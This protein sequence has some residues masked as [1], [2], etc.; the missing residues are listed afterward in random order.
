MA[1]HQTDDKPSSEPMLVCC[2]DEYMHHLA[3]MS[4]KKS[5][6]TAMI[7]GLPCNEYNH[8]FVPDYCISISNVLEFPACF[9]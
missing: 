6:D 2:T 9:H 4:K 5:N 1:W 8:G 3:L 7:T